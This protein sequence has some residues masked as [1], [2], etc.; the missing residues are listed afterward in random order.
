MERAAHRVK[1]GEY[2]THF[3]V[4][5]AFQASFWQLSLRER[6]ALGSATLSVV[7]YSDSNGDFVEGERAK[8]RQQ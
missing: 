7:F 4:V 8:G 3:N 1:N 6:L 2:A 5:L